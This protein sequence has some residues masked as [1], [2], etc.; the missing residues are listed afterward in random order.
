MPR[1]PSPSSDRAWR[2][3]TLTVPAEAVDA[4]TGVLLDLGAEGLVEDYPELLDEGPAVAATL[5][6]P[7]PPLPASGTVD[8]AGYLPTSSSAP[9]IETALRARISGLTEIF[10]ALQTVAVTIETVRD[11]D[12]GKSWR[13]HFTGIDVGHGLHVRPSWIPSRG[14]DRIELIVD[15]SMAFGT[16]THF[17]TA[18]CLEALEQGIRPGCSVLDIGTGTGVLAIAAAKLGASRIVALDLEHEDVAVAEH[19]VELNG[20]ARQVALSTGTVTDAAGRFDV[21]AANLLAP[22]LRAFASDLAAFLAPGGLLIASG[23]L[24]GQEAEVLQAFEAVDFRAV[25]RRSDGEWVQL[26]LQP[27]EGGHP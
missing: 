9:E 15:P 24:V 1:S 3:V 12:W 11:E 16:G 6:A 20:V 22:V 17:T 2:R 14:D 10:P 21:V 19:N 27:G 8:L 25:H 18:A 4:L 13:D 5:W 7:P 26:S 23:L